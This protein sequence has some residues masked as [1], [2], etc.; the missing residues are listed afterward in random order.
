MSRPALF[1]LVGAIA[2]AF[3][4][5]TLDSYP[6][7]A[8][9]DDA[10]Y[11]ILAKSL[12][13]GQGYRALNLPGAPPNTHFPPGYPA[14]L[15]LIWRLAPSFPQNVIWF[16]ALNM[17]CFAVAAV[18]MVRF[19]LALALGR[20]WTAALGII[21]AISVP[22][23]ILVALVLSEPLFLCLVVLLLPFLE[24]FVHDRPRERADWHAVGIG[25]AI[26]VCTLVRAHGIV[27]VPV[28]VLLLARRRRWR[29]LLL[30]VAACL[31]IILPWQL[32]CA[33]HAGIVPTPLLGEYESYTAW[34]VRGYREMGFSMIMRTLARTIEDGALMFAVL[35]SPVRGAVA[36]SVTL[37]ML[38]V[39]AAAGM[40]AEWRRVPVTLL[41]LAGYFVIVAL[42]PYQ[43]DRFIWGMWPLLMLVLVLGVRAGWRKE[44]N[45]A[46]RAIVLVSTAWVVMGYGA[47]EYRAVRGQWWSSIPRGA[48]LHIGFAVQWARSRTA[49]DD[50]IATDNEGPIYLYTGRHTVPVRPLTTRQYLEDASPQQEAADGLLPVLAAYPARTVI[51]HLSAAYLMAMHLA[52]LPAP[53]LALQATSAG[54]AAFAVLVP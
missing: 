23:L 28:L 52:Q 48:A 54:G 27:L 29:D 10:M 33:R 2:A 37:V 22:S 34:W 20:A 25:I 6:I 21:T 53:R 19:A 15:S 8:G 18:G 50:V 9:A 36:H 13:T 30:V 41:F 40:A 47:Y 7:G 39:L 32:W 44:R 12:A 38:V 3:A 43:P 4:V 1:A 26:G 11:I 16:K 35:F 31:V 49:P 17:V 46:F 45:P 51:V 14:I 42:W 24:R 5:A